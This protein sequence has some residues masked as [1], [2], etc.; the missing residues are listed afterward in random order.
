MPHP[1]LMVRRPA[2]RD[3]WIRA[4]HRTRT[5][6]QRVR[7]LSLAGT[8]TGGECWIPVPLPPPAPCVPISVDD[9]PPYVAMRRRRSRSVL[10]QHSAKETPTVERRIRTSQLAPLHERIT[11]RH[12]FGPTRRYETQP[13]AIIRSMYACELERRRLIIYAL[14]RRP[15]YILSDGESASFDREL[16]HMAKFGTHDPRR[17]AGQQADREAG[18]HFWTDNVELLRCEQRLVERVLCV[19]RRGNEEIRREALRDC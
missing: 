18:Y 4:C 16:I 15:E 8:R 7:R 3:A 12:E 17:V 19:A 5:S 6:T 10:N 13:Y 11:V 1:R 2:G 14:A 9:S